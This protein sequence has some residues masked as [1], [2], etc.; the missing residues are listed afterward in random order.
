M[1]KH[2]KT[3]LVLGVVFLAQYHSS[4]TFAQQPK[5]QLNC[6][7]NEGQVKPKIPQ[8]S[9]DELAAYRA[10]YPPCADPNATKIIRVNLHFILDDMGEKNFQE[11]AD[12][13]G[14]IHYDGYK[15]GE[16][17]INKCNREWAG[18]DNG[19]SCPMEIVCRLVNLLKPFRLF[20]ANTL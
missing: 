10:M 3:L 7:V 12:G 18:Q 2:L 14:N 19:T 17:V 8:P 16:E 9:P 6:A 4:K 11:Y 13:Y 15:F 20:P 1:L 5:I